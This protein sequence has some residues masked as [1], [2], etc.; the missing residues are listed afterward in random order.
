[1]RARRLALGLVV[2]AL[3]LAATA[4]AHQLGKGKPGAMIKRAGGVNFVSTCRFSHRAPDD[5]IVFPGHPGFSH[6]HSFVGN[7]TTDA[8]ST[9]ASLQA[10]ST[11]CRRIGDKAGYWMPTL[12]DNDTPVAPIGATIYYRRRTKEKVKPFPGGLK[13]IAGDSKAQSAQSLRITFWN[14]GPNAGIAP[15]STVPTCPDAAANGLRL[16]VSFPNCWDGQNLD[17]AD[18]KSHMAYSTAGR[19][20][21]DHPVAV[22]AISLIYRYPIQGDSSVYLSSGGQFSAHADFFNAWDE[23]TLARLVDGCLNALVHCGVHN[24]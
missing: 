4:S 10:G 18:H 5:P 6:D 14:C 19:C 23:E 12:A 2:A 11:T 21:A 9:L 22:P 16:H 8:F 17:S 20:P 24:P 7:T 3:G 1:M 15:S 13:M